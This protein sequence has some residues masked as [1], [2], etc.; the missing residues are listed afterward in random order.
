[1]ARAGFEA[2]QEPTAAEGAEFLGKYGHLLPDERWYSPHFGR[3]IESAYR[4]REVP[5]V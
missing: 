5:A 3:S 2:R 4:L 1:V